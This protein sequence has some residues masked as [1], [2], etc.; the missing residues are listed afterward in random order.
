VSRTVPGKPKRSAPALRRDGATTT[1]RSHELH[2]AV[3]ERIVEIAARFGFWLATDELVE[4]ICECGDVSCRERLLVPT[5]VFD[6]VRQQ[7]G[8]FVVAHRHAYT[9]LVGGGDGYAVIEPSS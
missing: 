9:P 2:R 7:P 5:E 3:N 1:L 4:L 6:R 8:R